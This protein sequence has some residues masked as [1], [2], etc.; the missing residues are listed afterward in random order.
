MVSRQHAESLRIEPASPNHEAT[1]W[2]GHQSTIAAQLYP[3]PLVH[4][5]RL[6]TSLRGEVLSIR[7][8]A[9]IPVAF[10]PTMLASEREHHA[11][12]SS[13]FVQS[14]T[15]PISQQMMR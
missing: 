9:R 2:F 5:Q 1:S 8:G 6:H 10:F 12:G 13:L 4:I 14:S 15:P 7:Q 3:E 11:R